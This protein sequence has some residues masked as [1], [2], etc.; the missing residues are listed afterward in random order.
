MNNVYRNH[1]I[2]K[3]KRFD[4]VERKIQHMVNLGLIDPKKKNAGYG[5]HGGAC[6]DWLKDAQDEYRKASYHAANDKLLADI[7]ISIF[8]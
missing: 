3:K 1:P 6:P 7:A 5:Q 4:Y 8:N 2:D